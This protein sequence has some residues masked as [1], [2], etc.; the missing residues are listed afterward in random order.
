MQ[1]EEVERDELG[2][3]LSP[4]KI[5]HLSRGEGTLRTL[6]AGSKGTQLGLQS[7]RVVI[8][9]LREVVDEGLP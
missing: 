3:G 4:V 1:A 2:F 6:P 8:V 5:V 7:S 9:L